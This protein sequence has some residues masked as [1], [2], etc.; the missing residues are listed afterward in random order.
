MK[1][2]LF[3]LFL[4]LTGIGTIAFTNSV[5]AGSGLYEKPDVWISINGE[6][7]ENNNYVVSGGDTVVVQILQENSTQKSYTGQMIQQIPTF[8]ENITISSSGKLKF[9]SKNSEAQKNKGCFLNNKNKPSLTCYS[10]PNGSQITYSA[11]ISENI[12]L[13][14]S[15]KMNTKVLYKNQKGKNIIMKNQKTFEMDQEINIWDEEED[16]NLNIDDN[17][18]CAFQVSTGEVMR[19]CATPPSVYWTSQ[20][21]CNGIKNCGIVSPTPTPPPSQEMGSIV[22]T[23]N[24]PGAKVFFS[25][26]GSSFY[27]Y[28]Q[29]SN[30][31]IPSASSTTYTIKL[32]KPGYAD[33]IQTQTLTAGKTITFNANL[34]PNPVN[35]N[36]GNISVLSNVPGAQIW[37]SFNGGAFTNSGQVSNFNFSNV[38]SGTYTA[39]LVKPGYA[40]WIQTQTLTAGK[41]MIFNATLVPVK[42]VVE[43]SVLTLSSGKNPVIGTK[44][45]E[46]LKFEVKAGSTKLTLD[47]VQVVGTVTDV[48][49]FKDMPSFLDNTRISKIS[50]YRVEGTTN[51]LLD[52]LSGSQ[53]AAG[54]GT[55]DGFKSVIEANKTATYLI[56]FDISDDETNIGDTLK[57]SLRSLLL[58]DAYSSSRVENV[59]IDGLNIAT[60]PLSLSTRTTTL[61]GVGKLAIETDNT[62]PLTDKAKYV[63]GGTESDFVASYNLTATN[64][65]ILLRD[66][67]LAETSGA[68]E[69]QVKSALSEVVLYKAD[70]KTV[71][72]RK[73]VTGKNINFTD[74]NYTVPEGSENIYVAVVA[75]KQGKNQAGSIVSGLTFAMKV[76]KADGA[77][78]SKTVKGDDVFTTITG[79]NAITD[80][81]AA[82]DDSSYAFS[83]IPTKISNVEFVNTYGGQTVATK[84]T[85]GENTVAILKITT[86]SSN[87]TDATDGTSLKTL[88][89]ELYF[90]VYYG[91]LSGSGTP[92]AITIEK[93]NGTGDY[94]ASVN[95]VGNVGIN[96]VGNVAT[97]NLSS[98][99]A[100]N[101]EIDNGTSVYYAIKATVSL[102]TASTSPQG[103]VQIKAESLDSGSIGYKSDDLDGLELGVPARAALL[104]KNL[105]KIEGTKVSQ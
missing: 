79:A 103:Y 23:S 67:T 102:D 40:D 44:E 86:A 14:E 1:R 37:Y 43:V 5:N 91:G 2:L 52:T 98:F 58:Y 3:L 38:A 70:G 51:V 85:N 11:T 15:S 87:N 35:I 104:I 32:V 61:K 62:N 17:N 95:I 4:I 78:S 16:D 101:A 24:P 41:T 34:V 10:F 74:I 72:A 50:L 93:I 28:Q 68:T 57:L 47:E 54:V 84:L 55:F 83:V 99:D 13:E 82:A 30:I 29:N 53:L 75:Q 36:T 63:L 48:A 88:L 77:S 97:A 45:V 12:F 20:R 90:N 46:G 8:F 81:G 26:S 76:T 65:G 71:I 100:V 19:K 39:K 105:T 73:A 22:I 49:P 69:A 66:I 6:M 31:T 33:W 60:S 9:Y 80:N 7:T 27:D 89:S 92:S 25:I 59:T 42:S 94:T 96:I 64:E 21:K 18:Y 56:T